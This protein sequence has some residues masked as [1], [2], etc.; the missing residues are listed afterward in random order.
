ML[1]RE[2]AAGHQRVGKRASA[3]GTRAFAL[4]RNGTGEGLGRSGAEERER[5]VRERALGSLAI[6]EEQLQHALR[7][8]L[9][10]QR[11]GERNRRLDAPG[12]G[13]HASPIAGQN[14]LAASHRCNGK[15]IARPGHE[16]RRRAAAKGRER[17]QPV[18]LSSVDGCGVGT[19]RSR[20]LARRHATDLA[21]IAARQQR[22]AR[23]REIDPGGA[24][25]VR[26]P[27]VEHERELDRDVAHELALGL[28]QRL[29][30]GAQDLQHRTRPSS[31]LDR[32]G[33]A[34][35]V[36]AARLQPPRE[37]RFAELSRKGRLAASERV[38][39][40][41]AHRPARACELGRVRRRV[42]LHRSRDHGS[43]VGLELLHEHELRVAQ[44]PRRAGKQREGT[45]L[46]ARDRSLGGAVD[47]GEARGQPLSARGG[48]S[49]FERAGRDL[50]EPVGQ[51]HVLGAERFA[52]IASAERDRDRTAGRVSDRERDQRLGTTLAFERHRLGEVRDDRAGARE[53]LLHEAEVCPQLPALRP[54]RRATDRRDDRA[55]AIRLDLG[56]GRPVTREAV[57]SSAG[58][59][60]EHGI[61]VGRRAGEGRGG[62]AHT[63]GDRG[64]PAQRRAVRRVEL[65]RGRS[66]EALDERNSGR[67]KTLVADAVERRV[68]RVQRAHERHE[69]EPLLD[70]GSDVTLE[71]ER[72]E[73]R[74]RGIGE[75][76]LE[77]GER[78]A[79]SRAH[80]RERHTLGR[81]HLV[82]RQRKI[83]DQARPVL[84]EH[85]LRIGRRGERLGGAHCRLS[86]R[87]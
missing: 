53:G 79:D 75:T 10:E 4:D 14:R 67:R 40:G 39:N 20:S 83:L 49:G 66:H 8:A 7:L 15:R 38:G 44:L 74:A 35:E 47:V 65:A 48:L 55:P 63:V 61:G 30:P 36:A 41:T 57:G 2:R 18:T 84:G 58:D 42:R 87:R 82:G 56:D 26:R 22:V 17:L 80:A 62:A 16:R 33:D 71:R 9:G 69:R 34:D 77:R 70:A 43:A 46:V 54:P 29:G 21:D 76:L 6:A 5:R 28:A 45:R 86:I 64:A 11:Q 78:V 85:L 3:V 1:D 72:A 50:A 81:Q 52:S 60:L 32:K 12:K 25:G 31:R 68:A 51:R 24:R 13:G 59:G 27:G 73:R 19:A 23:R 37:R